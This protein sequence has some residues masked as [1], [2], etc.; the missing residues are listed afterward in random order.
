MTRQSGGGPGH[1][2]TRPSIRDWLGSHRHY[3]WIAVALLWFCGFFNYTD[4]QA[5][6]AVLPAIEVEFRLT[7]DQIGWLGSAFMVFYSLTRLRSPVMPSTA[8]RAQALDPARPG[9]LEP[10]LRI[11]GVRPELCATAGFARRRGPG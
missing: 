11:D 9:F 6:S 1:A 2:E 5:L 8:F 3:P 10:D 4:R 7:D